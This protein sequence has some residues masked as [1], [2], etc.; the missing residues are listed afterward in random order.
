MHWSDQRAQRPDDGSGHVH[1]R[2]V[3]T[4]GDSLVLSAPY[5]V[6]VEQQPPG[7]DGSNAMPWCR[8]FLVSPQAPAC[9][10][11]VTMAGPPRHRVALKPG[12]ALYMPANV[13][14]HFFFPVGMRMIAWHFRLEWAPGVD[15]CADLTRLVRRDLSASAYDELA[16]AVAGAE[17]G[18]IARARGAMLAIVG[19]FIEEPVADVA[20]R[21]HARARFAGVLARIDERP[22]AGLSVSEMARSSGLG[23]EAFSRRFRRDLGMTPREHL[24][25]VLVRHACQRLIAGEAVAAVAEALGFSSPYWFSRFFK[26]RLGVPP[27]AFGTLV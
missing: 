6:M 17:A 24:R 20:R 9:D 26:A 4:L 3:E 14:L 10:A 1:Q 12:T 13:R 15:A 23:R 19:S 18:A 2:G 5:V 25:R 22:D 7:V 21:L 8:L 27:S 11:A 16:G